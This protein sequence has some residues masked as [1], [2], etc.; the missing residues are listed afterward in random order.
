M[1]RCIRA[2][3]D[4]HALPACQLE[5]MADLSLPTYIRDGLVE[6]PVG[7]ELWERAFTVAPLV[8]VGTK[9]GRRLRLRPQAHGDAARL[10]G[11][12]LL[13]LQLRGT[14]PTGT[15]SSIPSSRSAFPGPEQIVESSL[16]AGGRF[17]GGAKPTLTAVPSVPARVVDGRLVE[18]CSAL[19]GVRPRADRRRLR[20]EQP[21]RRAGGGRVRSP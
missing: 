11:L 20:A 6:L 15:C 3:P 21:D 17:E 7:P 5:V 10:G 13:R 9:E 1:R 16:A 18:G 2:R 8:L 19:S 12:L 14:R 4:A